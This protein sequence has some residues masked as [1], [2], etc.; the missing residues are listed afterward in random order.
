M[1]K[2]E[3]YNNDDTTV[4][5]YKL[6]ADYLNFRM[7][8][9]FQ[10]SP[11]EAEEIYLQCLDYVQEYIG[12]R[13]TNVIASSRVPVLNRNGVFTLTDSYKELEEAILLLSDA[14]D[15][16]EGEVTKDWK[17]QVEVLVKFYYSLL[18]DMQCVLHMFEEKSHGVSGFCCLREGDNVYLLPFALNENDD[19]WSLY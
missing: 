16:T 14:F 12:L 18:K 7:N 3:I 9:D 4:E 15:N 8:N 5:M 1:D 13:G 6:F 10:L 11:I 2:V 17:I 19:Y